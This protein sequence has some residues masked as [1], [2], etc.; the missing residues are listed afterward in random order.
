LLI[1]AHAPLWPLLAAENCG[2][3]DIDARFRMFSFGASL[4]YAVTGSSPFEKAR[5]PNLSPGP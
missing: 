2:T 3:L 5:A 1:E 4:Y